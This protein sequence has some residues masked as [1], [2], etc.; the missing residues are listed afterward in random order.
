MN[1]TAS[2]TTRDGRT[3]AVKD[4][5]NLH[6][7]SILRRGMRKVAKQLQEK[8]LDEL[9]AGITGDGGCEYLAEVNSTPY[10]EKAGNPRVLLAHLEN[11]KLYG[12]LVTEARA[13]AKAARQH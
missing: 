5:D 7:H 9:A 12:P 3:I 2:W 1:D 6:L 8:G 4:L 10:F 13:R 11:S